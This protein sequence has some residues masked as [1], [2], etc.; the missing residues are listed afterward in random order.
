MYFTE[1]WQPAGR[2]SEVIMGIPA[3]WKVLQMA[4]FYTESL[5]KDH[6]KV[7]QP[8]LLLQHVS[9]SGRYPWS[10]TQPKLKWQGHWG[11]D[12]LHP[13]FVRLRTIKFNWMNKDGLKLIS[14]SYP[15][16]KRAT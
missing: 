14:R 1:T 5:T 3:H 6:F 16:T 10:E 8:N 9:N 15:T 11:P 4:K 12:F 7:Q 2:M 13:K